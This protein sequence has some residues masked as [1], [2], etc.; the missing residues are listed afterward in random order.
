[1]ERSGEDSKSTGLGK[2]QT[3]KG[4]KEWEKYEDPTG[5]AK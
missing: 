1:M 2:V 4:A 5:R 3:D